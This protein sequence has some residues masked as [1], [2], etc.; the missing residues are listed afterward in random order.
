MT[1]LQTIHLIELNLLP[2]AHIITQ[3]SNSFNFNFKDNFSPWSG[4]GSIEGINGLLL[5]KYSN[6]LTYL[7][8][9]PVGGSTI[10]SYMKSYNNSKLTPTYLC[11]V[12]GMGTHSKVDIEPRSIFPF[13]IS[14][15]QESFA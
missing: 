5:P 7:T 13:T 12:D 6:H 9:K 2:H 14:F 8:H 1:L 11:I 4:H 15:V 3:T 10:L